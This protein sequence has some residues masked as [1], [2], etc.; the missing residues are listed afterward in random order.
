MREDSSVSTCVDLCNDH[1]QDTDLVSLRKDL[2]YA[3]PYGNTHPSPSTILN[4]WQPLVYL[5]FASFHH[6]NNVV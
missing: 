1:N 4:S 2:P 6:F 5:P 3:T